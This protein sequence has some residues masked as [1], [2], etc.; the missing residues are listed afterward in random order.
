MDLEPNKPPRRLLL[1][2]RR[3]VEWV[4]R[5]KVGEPLPEPHCWALRPMESVVRTLVDL[6]V[7]PPPAPGADI[8]QQAS[9]AAQRWLDEHPADG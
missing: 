7:M 1:S 8:A 4:A 2:E 5:A 3:L 6:R 9:A